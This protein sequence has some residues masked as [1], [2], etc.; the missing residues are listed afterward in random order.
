M[1][2]VDLVD[3]DLPP[4]DAVLMIAAHASRAQILC[5][6]LDPTIYLLRRGQFPKVDISSRRRL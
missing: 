2:P 3:A 4:A 5:E 6:F 1:S